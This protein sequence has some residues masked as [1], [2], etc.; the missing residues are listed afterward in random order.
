LLGASLAGVVMPPLVTALVDG[1]GWRAAYLV[2]A[3][4]TVVFLV[5]LVVFLFKDRPEEVGETRDGRRYVAKQGPPAPEAASEERLWHWTEMLK[6]KAF[7]SI[8]LMFGAMG[9]VYSA[10]ML[11]LFGHIKDIGLTSSD[12]AYVLSVTALFAALGKPIVGW[13]ADAWGARVTIWMALACQG[14]ALVIFAEAATFLVAALAGCVYGFGYSGMSPLRTFAL[15]VTIGNRSFGSAT[16]VIRIV[17]LPL[18]ISASPLAG[19]IYDQTGSYRIA[20]LIL[21]GLMAVSCIGPLLIRAGGAVERRRQ[22]NPSSPAPVMSTPAR[23]EGR[24]DS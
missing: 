5:P 9:C 11:H 24:A 21:A 8:A 15:S 2:F 7:W 20:F 10:T 6:N 1:I 13:M 12:A 4:I 22:S 23:K 18:V 3:A 17:E 14:V 19:F 16:G